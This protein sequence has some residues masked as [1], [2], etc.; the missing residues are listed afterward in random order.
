M[1]HLFLSCH[2]DIRNM[3]SASYWYKKSSQKTADLPVSEAV[4]GSAEGKCS[5]ILRHFLAS[6]LHLL[7]ISKPAA[8]C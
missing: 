1:T 3:Q 6:H 8:L 5:L 4:R 7:L 2:G